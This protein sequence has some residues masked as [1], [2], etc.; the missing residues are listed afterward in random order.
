MEQ[1]GRRLKPAVVAHAAVGEP[2]NPPGVNS[3]PVD[4]R[5]WRGGNSLELATDDPIRIPTSHQPLKK[6]LLQVGDCGARPP[7]KCLVFFDAL[8]HRWHEEEV[9]RAS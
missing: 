3:G 7:P 8:V 4:R 1:P 5:R 6:L 9:L 2:P